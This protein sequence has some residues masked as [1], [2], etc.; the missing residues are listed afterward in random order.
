[1]Q[2]YRDELQQ[3]GV[4][5]DSQ[6]NIFNLT[7]PQEYSCKVLTFTETH[8]ILSL[9]LLPSVATQPSLQVTFLGLYYFDGPLFWKGANFERGNLQESIDLWKKVYPHE[10][11]ARLQEIAQ[12]FGSYLVQT[13]SSQIRILATGR[14]KPQVWSP[15]Y[16]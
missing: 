4:P 11:S 12:T 7:A 14:N 2:V 3:E 1:M 16:F 6:T 10:K 5:V 9:R 15:A 13:E 8:P